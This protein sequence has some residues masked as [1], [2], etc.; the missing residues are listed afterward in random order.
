MEIRETKQDCVI[1]QSSLYST[2]EKKKE[3]PTPLIR[4]GNLK[5]KI[6][7]TGDYGLLRSHQQEQCFSLTTFQSEQYFSVNF[8]QVSDKQTALWT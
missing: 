7:N 8:S 5:K 3:K 2:R 1:E 4:T 6:K